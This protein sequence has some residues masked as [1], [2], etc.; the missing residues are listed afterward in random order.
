MKAFVSGQAATAVMIDEENIHSIGLDALHPI[1]RRASDLPILFHGSSDVR[2]VVCDSKE[3]LL[4]ELELEWQ[5]D[6]SLHLSLL[7]L[8][9]QEDRDVRKEAT[10]CIED[11]FSADVVREFVANRLYS[12]PLPDQADIEGATALAEEAQSNRLRTFLVELADQQSEIAARLQVWL[13]LP[14]SL[15]GST[16]AKDKFRL[17]AVEAGAFRMFVTYRGRSDAALFQML[18]HPLFRGSAQARQVLQAW[19][20]PFKESIHNTEFIIEEAD[21]IAALPH[22]DPE[23]TRGTGGHEAYLRVEKQKDAIKSLLRSGNRDRALTYT[24]QLVEAQRRESGREHLAKSLCDLGA[25]A[26]DLGD[27]GLQLDLATWAIQEVPDDAWSHGQVGEAYRAL[28]NYD[29]ALSAF[30]MAGALGAE[31]I[32]L[33]GRAQVLKDLGQ[34]QEAMAIFDKC[35]EVFPDDLVSRNGRAAAL[36]SF[37]RFDEALQ[38]YDE[39]CERIPCDAVSMAGRAEV[40]KDMGR[41]DDALKEL[42]ETILMFPD[43]VIP[44]CA[45]GV[46]LREMGRLDEALEWFRDVGVRFPLSVVARNGIARIQEELGDFEAALETYRQVTRDV[47]LDPFASIGIAQIERKRGNLQVALSAYRGLMEQF[48]RNGLV[49]NGLASVLTVMGE[50]EEARGLLPHYPPASSNEW[51][52]YHIRGMTHLRSG[53]LDR[54]EEIFQHGLAECPWAYEWSYFQT[55]LASL[56]V[57]RR[58][59]PEAIELLKSPLSVPILPVA[60]LIRMHAHGALGQHD[61]LQSAYNSTSGARSPLILRLRDQLITRFEPGGNTPLDEA[62]GSLFQQECDTLLLAA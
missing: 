18:V 2:S 54:A 28:G 39:L 38:L 33:L 42:D 32:A 52:A 21:D 24:K 58:R 19:A 5:K 3:E 1:E 59:Y 48:P 36:A 23:T 61:E 12:A 14:I 31:R 27:S 7:L 13:D 46:V 30:A 60:S 53:E 55:A 9:A 6:R 4:A 22:I 34:L 17:A 16:H 45:R 20:A 57:R 56:E 11:F 43:D 35:A 25:F 44:R 10:A 50:Y 37:G 41:L 51:I 26:K 49:R 8:D 29:K 15:F 47:P 40:L 62:E